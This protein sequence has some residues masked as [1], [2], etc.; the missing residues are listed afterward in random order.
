MSSIRHYTL[1]DRLCMGL[2]QSI[3]ALTDNVKTTGAAYPAKNI[4]EAELTTAER[5]TSAAFM[6]INHAGEICAQALYNG[7]ALVSRENYVQEKMQQAAMEESDHLSWCRKRLDE[8]GSH[9]SYLNPFW[10]IGSYCIG[11]T[12][13]LIGDAWSLGFVAETETQVIKHL[14]G[15]LYSL[16]KVDQRSYHILV[17]MEEDESK[18][19]AEAIGA[20]AKELPET[21]KKVMSLMSKVMVKTAAWV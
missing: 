17:K 6:R 19:R 8:L 9:T 3:R 15:H 1:L 11:M 10:Y 4:P 5:K 14:Q 2:D 18:H 13:G 21:V 12:A 20:G 7:Q 16:P